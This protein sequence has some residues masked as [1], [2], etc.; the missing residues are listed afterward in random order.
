MTPPPDHQSLRE[1]L[2]GPAAP[3]GEFTLAGSG[4]TVYLRRWPLADRLKVVALSRDA[5]RPAVEREAEILALVLCDA[6]NRRLFA[7]GDA[8]IMDVPFGADA[9]SLILAALAANGLSAE[10]KAGPPTS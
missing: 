9:E 2:S 5:T 3:A 10:K 1:K 4:V 6:E 7:D 8:A